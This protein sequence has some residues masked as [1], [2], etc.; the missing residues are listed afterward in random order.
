MSSGRQTGVE[1]EAETG[2]KDRPRRIISGIVAPQSACPQG[3][4]LIHLP[5]IVAVGARGVHRLN[6]KSNFAV[7]GHLNDPQMIA[8]GR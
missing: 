3:K 1:C 4:A 6:G 5:R 7:V 2:Y 8:R